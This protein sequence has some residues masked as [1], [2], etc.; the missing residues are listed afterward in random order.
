[1]KY[2]TMIA[3]PSLAVLL[4]V[5]L[6]G[7]LYAQYHAAEVRIVNQSQRTM[8]IK[9]M[10]NT[11]QSAVKYYEVSIPANGKGAV[12]ISQ[13]GTYYLKIKAEYPGRDPVYSMGDPFECHVG[14]TGYS[15]LTFTYTIDERALTAEGKSISQS[16][17]D[18]DRD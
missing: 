5:G 18:K 14:P 12:G 16:E 11:T 9:V 17:F 3:K 8:E 10:Q 7:S 4:L 1:M 2:M 13:T 6:H 15:V